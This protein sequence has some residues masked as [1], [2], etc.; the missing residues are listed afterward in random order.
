M[1]NSLKDLYEILFLMENPLFME[2]G[3]FF[4]E[5]VYIR[6]NSELNVAVERD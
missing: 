4:P 1:R 5:D 6:N 3:F 2:N